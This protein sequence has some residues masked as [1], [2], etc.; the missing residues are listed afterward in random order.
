MSRL[1]CMCVSA[2][3]AVTRRDETR[4]DE[5]ERNETQA[6]KSR[7]IPFF[8]LYTWLCRW[9]DGW[10][11]G[12]VRDGW[13][14]RG[15]GDVLELATGLCERYGR[16]FGGETDAPRR[17]GELRGR[18]GKREAPRVAGCAADKQ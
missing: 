5:T 9:L 10:L 11:A 15:P 7:R 17:E 4:R 14:G 1:A 18:K 3:P 8:L 13:S 12:R 16:D 2:R 6:G